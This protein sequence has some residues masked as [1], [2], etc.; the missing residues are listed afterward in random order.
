LAGRS[1]DIF[2]PT[3]YD[4]YIIEKGDGKMVRV[5]YTIKGEDKLLQDKEE[6]FYS[7]RLAF[8]FMRH[9]MTLGGLVGKPTIERIER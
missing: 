4:S 2:P 1:L 7:L 8:S 9:L 6:T 5:S 3:I